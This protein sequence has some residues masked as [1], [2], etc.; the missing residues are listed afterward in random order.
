MNKLTIYFGLLF[1]L[2]S[3]F[4]IAQNLIVIKNDKEIIKISKQVVF[5]EDKNNNLGVQDIL[6]DKLQ[7]SFKQNNKKTISFNF[8]ESSFWI[9][10]SIFNQQKEPIALKIEN[11]LLDTI[12]LYIVQDKKVVYYKQAGLLI[13]FK[14][15]DIN[16]NA[17]IFN[18]P[19][20][21][22]AIYDIYIKTNSRLPVEIFASISSKD[23]I[24]E[25]TINN[26]FIQ[27]IYFGFILLMICYN[28]FIYSTTKDIDYLLYV[29]S[30]FCVGISYLVNQSYLYQFFYPDNIFV[31]IFINYITITC[32]TI[33]ANIIFAMKFLHIKYYFNFSYY[34]AISLIVLLFL[35]IVLNIIGYNKLTF[36]SSQFILL[37]IACLGVSIPY[38]IYKKGFKP[39][40]FF[41]LAWTGIIL[42]G[43]ID[44][45]KANQFLPANEFTNNAYRIGT[46]LEMLLLS[47]A[48]ANKINFYKESKLNAQKENLALV[49]KNLELAKNNIYLINEQNAILEEKV[50][51]RTVELQKANRE[52]LEQNEELH[53]QERE[54]RQI[55]SEI[56]KQ[57][58]LIEMQNE[59]LKNTSYRLNTS[60]RYA[61][62]IQNLILPEKHKLDDFFQEHFAIYLPKDVVSGDFY[63]FVELGWD[64]KW[65]KEN[66]AL[67]QSINPEYITYKSILTVV[68]CTGHGVPG[69]F[70]TM[71]VHTLLHEIVEIKKIK[72][73][74]FILQNLHSGIKNLLKQYNSKNSDGM[75]ISICY[76]EKD[77]IKKECKVTFAGAKGLA[78]YVQDNQVKA[79]KSE[80]YSIGGNISKERT[81]TNQEVILKEGSF[82]YF[83]TDGYID[84]NNADRDKFGSNNF[85][86][87][88]NKLCYLSIKEQEQ[89]ILSI[90][91]KH[92]GKEEQRD[93][94]S[95]IG[96]KL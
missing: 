31:N 93:D 46:A 81:F 72:N 79:F 5:L 22:D 24:L 44:I 41:L 47:F 94:I 92:Q 90:L 67:L 96:I 23:I 12:Q 49:E 48:L 60:I 84:Q 62:H 71:I 50:K 14:D 51:E 55:N 95:V 69:A 4:V 3:N 68:D 28:L 10:F 2:L 77:S 30:C 29:F 58:E 1:I 74:A 21:Q 64:N 54:F 91:K 85:K 32:L 34:V 20:S 78:F 42:G 43:V 70:M 73:P 63:W 16:T 65:K 15:R 75:D 26:K 89:E 80:R 39:A 27:G 38:Y 57:K 6:K 7:S 76:F 11:T 86:L 36:V 13:P 45:L 40:L 8:S 52:I 83:I 17:Y 33:I 37:I 87:L 61:Q 25:Q 59:E 82:I 9:K 66:Q 18:L 35:L 19:L 88:L 53:S 56:F